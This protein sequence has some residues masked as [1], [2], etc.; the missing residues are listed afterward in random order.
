[1]KKP[2][3]ATIFAILASISTLAGQSGNPRT[4]SWSGVI[5]NGIC[6]PDEAFAEAAKCTDPAPGAPLALYDDTIRQVYALEPQEQAKGHL[7]D[8]VTVQGALDANK[9]QVASLQMFSEVGLRTGE[10]AP[11]FSARD[12]FGNTQTLET[13]KGAKGTVLL[14]YRSADWCPYCKGQLIQL[15]AARQRFEEQGIKLAG[16]SYDSVE[17]LKFFSDRRKIEFPLL[18]DPDSK[19]IRMYQVLNSEAVG[20]NEGMA[21][22]GYFFIDPKGNIRE[23]FFE[24]KYR[25]RLTGN[26]VLSKLF[27]ALGEEVSDAVEAPH[28]QLHVGQSDRTAV[29][30][31]LVTLTA[32]VQLPPDVHVYAPGT[33]G[34]KAIK[35]TIDPQS[36]FAL[37]Q[38]SY[39]AA[40][41]LYL[42]AI[43]EKVPVFEGTFKIRQELKANSA[44]DF[45]GALGADGKQVTVKGTLEYQACDSK[46]CFL[47]ASVP[48]EWHLQIVPL[49][50][51]RA[52]EDIRHK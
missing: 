40:K 47:P 48:V 8:S 17:I 42:P 43:K 32:D 38:A 51:Q 49:D 44:T 15:Q 24:A 29:P 46:I 21:R 7:G 9:I 25:E 5:I 45:S 10:K 39:P 28:L 41:I 11:D 3:F 2:L 13:L 19:I 50:R 37:K 4:G 34:Y 33:K 12:Q 35:L 16:V 20:P 6:T 30:G 26:T 23:K 18:S 27:P 31:N 14:F 36:D 1:M 52:P 22:P